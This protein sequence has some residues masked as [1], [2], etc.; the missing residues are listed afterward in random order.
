MSATPITPPLAGAWDNTA[1]TPKTPALAAAWSNS[2]AAPITPANDSRQNRGVVIT[3][4]DA[5]AF[6]VGLYTTT[7]DGSE[8]QWRLLDN[9]GATISTHTTSGGEAILG[10]SENFDGGSIV[11]ITEP[12]TLIELGIVNEY[13]GPA[14]VPAISVRGLGWLRS[15]TFDLEGAVITTADL[16]ALVVGEE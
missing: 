14:N 11:L 2:G 10:S 6:S 4:G 13:D 3:I 7:V 16:P 8:V 9:V 1:P 12:D 15:L 5:G